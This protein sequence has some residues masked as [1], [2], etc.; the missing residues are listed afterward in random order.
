MPTLMGVPV[1]LPQIGTAYAGTAGGVVATIQIGGAVSVP[2]YILVPIAGENFNFL[3]GLGGI[4]LLI[5][6]FLM[7]F[8]KRIK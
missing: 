4:C 2:S 1:Q 6:S 8:L 7:I 5:S 3:F